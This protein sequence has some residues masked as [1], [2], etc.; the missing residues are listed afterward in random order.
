MKNR[1]N[2]HN[3]NAPERVGNLLSKYFSVEDAP[4]SSRFADVSY[5]LL[6][7]TAGTAAAP[8]EVLV[9]HVMAFRTADYDER[10]GLANKLDYEKFIEAARGKLL[11]RRGEDFR[12][13]ELTSA[14]KS[15][16]ASTNTWTSEVTLICVVLEMYEHNE[17]VDS[18][19]AGAESTVCQD[20]PGCLER[21]TV[22]DISP[23]LTEA[24][25]TGPPDDPRG[26]ERLVAIRASLMCLE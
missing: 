10:K 23:P 5:Q 24:V 19:T 14:G 4:D 17:A 22:H 12:A 2:G 18:H 3:T 21:G 1:R 26:V 8:G 11:M 16:C 25:C 13:D 20:C 6:T 15:W 9:F 7:G